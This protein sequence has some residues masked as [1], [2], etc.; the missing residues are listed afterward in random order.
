MKKA[1]H[2]YGARDIMRWKFEEHHFPGIWGQHLGTIPKR[3]LMY[4]DGDA[5]HGKTEYQIQLTKML[6]AHFGKVRINNVE[7]GKHVQIQESSMRNK[8]HE[9]KAGKFAFCSVNDFNVMVD[10]LKKPQRGR[11]IIIDSISYFP[12]NTEQVQQLIE[13]FPNKS[14]V[15]VAYQAHYQSYRAV[16]HLCD[17][18]V[19]VENFVAHVQANRFGGTAE[20]YI[21]PEKYHAK[22]QFNQQVT[23]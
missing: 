13:L 6:A 15:F 19:R 20:L 14:F 1:V 11:V 5:G 17:I 21:W 23:L 16:R 22:K 3:F 7:Q 2:T 9:L 12:L 10:D 4:V 18:K 8:L